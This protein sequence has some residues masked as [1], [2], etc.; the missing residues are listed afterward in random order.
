M[1]KYFCYLVMGI[2]SAL[3]VFSA[4]WIKHVKHPEHPVLFILFTLSI[5]YTK[6]SF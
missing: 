4:P 5:I 1:A 6:H 2:L 3:F